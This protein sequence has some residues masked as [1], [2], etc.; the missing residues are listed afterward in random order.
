MQDSDSDW[1]D[2]GNDDEE[3]EE[4]NGPMKK[5]K[6]GSKSESDSSWETASS[7]SMGSTSASGGEDTGDAKSDGTKSTR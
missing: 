5:E 3:W 7:A 1:S 6:S 4:L 2:Y